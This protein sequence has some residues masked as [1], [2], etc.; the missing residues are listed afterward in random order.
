MSLTNF[1]LRGEQPRA[2]WKRL[3]TAQILKRFFFCERSLIVGASAWIPHLQDLDVKMAVPYYCWQN[4]E[5]ANSLR[6]RV[7]ELRF[8]S[9]M[10]DHEGADRPLATLLAEVRNA[11]TAAAFFTAWG[12]VAL[13]ALRDAYQEFL[14]RSDPLADAPTYR[15]LEL[16]LR[17]KEKQ[18]AALT[19][20]AAQEL[21]RDLANRALTDNW[22]AEFSSQLAFLGGVGTDAAPPDVEL[23][24]IP[25]SI[26]VSVPDLPARDPRYWSCRFYWPDIIDAEFPYGE[27]MLLQLRSAVSHLNEVW[28]VEHGGIIL[29]EFSDVLPWEWI[30]DAARWTYD[31]SRHCRMGQNRLAAWGFDP[32]EVPLGSY[33]YESAKGAEP[34][35]RLGMLYFFET[36]NIGRKPERTAVFKE[37][38]DQASEHD[39]DF[40]WADETIHATYGNRWLRAL[41]ELDAAK[42]PAADK[43]RNDCEFLVKRTIASASA[44]EKSAIIERARRMI[45]RANELA[46]Q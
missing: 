24:P 2:R 41:H 19:D 16:S 33:I 43:V 11:P 26:S 46:R 31:E 39:M 5:T 30:H 36:K 32:S 42:Y 15:F 21:A 9:R 23:T 18:I 25:G 22:I 38:G 27:G 7:F 35:Y 37:I 12:S 17:E 10:M 40:D 1:Y 13:A 8:P 14:D 4:A 6:E 45:E 34:I 28:A 29:S 44:T 3:D 20:W